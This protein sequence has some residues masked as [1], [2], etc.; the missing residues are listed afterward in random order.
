MERLIMQR[1]NVKLLLWLVG[2]AAAF[3]VGL[4]VVHQLQS[5]RIAEALLWQA[6][7]AEEQG[8]LKQAARYLAR[9]MEFQPEDL[10]ERAHLG[11][12]L[13]NPR[14]ADTYQSRANALFVLEQVVAREPDRQNLR[15]P[16]VRVATELGQFDLAAEHLQ[17]LLKEQPRD[18]EVHFLRGGWYEARKKYAR[19]QECYQ[20]AAELA[21][22][23]AKYPVRR[24][25]VLFAR[26]NKPREAQK[27]IEAARRQTPDDAG[28][29]LMAASLA[30]EQDQQA[31]AYRLLK[32][33]RRLYPRDPNFY[34]A[35]AGLLILD[36]R[37]PEAL[38]CLKDALK[39]LPR[40][41][42][43]DVLW[44]LTNL[45]LD[46]N[47]PGTLREA[48]EHIA[49]LQKAAL[50]PGATD[51]LDA[52]LL[53]GQ[54]DWAGA[55]RILE[56]IRPRLD[57]AANLVQEV[58]LYLGQCYEEL[59]DPGRRLDAYTL[60]VKANP[61]S[62]PARLGLAAA[63]GAM[64]KPDEALDNLKQATR[65]RRAPFRAWREYA[66]H[67]IARRRQQERPAWE[68]IDEALAEASRRARGPREAVEVVLLRAEALGARKE[69][70]QA[71]VYLE[72]EAETHP[73]QVDL[74]VAQVTL[75]EE[76]GQTDRAG[77][78]LEAMEKRFPAQV[79]PRL[80]RA[81][82]L[83]N[84][85]GVAA[86]N[87]LMKL[88]T[89]LERWD[90]EKQSN[91][92]RGLA[93][94]SYRANDL[95]AAARFLDR[96]AQLPLNRRDLRI[97]LRLFDLYLETK[98]QMGLTA[99][100]D[101][102]RRI[103]GEEGVWWRYGKASFL[104][105]QA[106]RSPKRGQLLDEAAGLLQAVAARRQRW[107]AVYTAQA[108]V[109]SL[110]G[111]QA[112]ALDLTRQALDMGENNPQI[113]RRLVR[114]VEA[115]ADREERSPEADQKFQHALDLAGHEPAIQVAYVRYLSVTG[116]REKALVAVEKAKSL[117]QSPQGRLALAQCY[118][119]VG[120]LKQA[121]AQYQ[122]ALGKRGADVATM[123]A[124][125]SFFMRTGLTEQAQPLLD[126]IL[127]RKISV[128]DADIAWARRARAVI[129]ADGSNFCKF[130]QALELIG[131][132]L[133]D[134]TG[135]AVEVS[136]PPGRERDATWRA[137][138]RVLAAQ[139][140]G[141]QRQQAIELL[142][143]LESRGRLEPDDRYLL[144][145]LFEAQGENGWRRARELLRALAAGHTNPAYH[146]HLAQSLLNHQ[147]YAEAS[148]AID[149]LARLE[150]TRAGREGAYGS[151]ELKARWLELTG[152]P[153]KA[154]RILQTYAGEKPLRAE[155]VLALAGLLARLT[156]VS[157]ALDQL[158]QLQGYP[159]EAVGGAAVGL[160]RSA[161]PADKDVARVEAFLLAALKKDPRSPVL[162]GQLADLY[163]LRGR[164]G[165][166][167]ARYRDV[168]ARD[169]DNVMALNNLAW[170]LAQRPKEAAEAE[171]LVNRAI[172]LLGP[173]PELLDTR[174]VV[175]LALGRSAAAVADLKQAN[176]DTP[177]PA[178]YFHL[179][180]ALH[181]E[182]RPAEALKALTK[183]KAAGLEPKGLHPAE[184]VQY[185]KINKELYER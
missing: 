2:G 138:A 66:R 146:G 144:A 69:F 47:E 22:K 60:A 161:K 57:Y 147:E 73:A 51:Y 34:K 95:R 16:L 158:E 53:M 9:Y 24:A 93:E 11:L 89:G 139:N 119:L 171:K 25:E 65:L 84:Q 7:R 101:Q 165:D 175:S 49:R 182:R 143:E 38:A 64:E 122:T 108:E 120:D 181:M 134:R 121:A 159:P 13:A 33:G 113:L 156:R 155:R 106:R 96:A 54:R 129:L 78:L 48:R 59:E 110:R 183:A 21:P 5:G 103:E 27:V 85:H 20:K 3:G 169:P 148:R 80:A 81:R 177:T 6:N 10:D 62:V 56:R 116:Q 42:H 26:L 107:S 72:R 173:R 112:Q 71:Q 152:Q 63:Q 18:A 117:L 153:D 111:N 8:D 124:A 149:K 172:N 82:F 150:K 41:H 1:I 46:M 87:S 154:L 164:F 98:N 79:E 55:A 160:L 114:Q 142:G 184:R 179:A 167:E 52:R 28:V 104:I 32:R 135:R 29:L 157:E 102:M 115:L 91:L 163:D 176:A 141:V 133:D 75:A 19:A 40:E 130:R 15:R 23:E 35:R 58:N 77:R 92:L 14:L 136:A 145:E 109:E 50:P 178:R 86:V 185:D 45:L 170:L 125:A 68:E 44:S 39:T 131:M 174:A 67:L 70:D 43:V 12:T 118:E 30:H 90:G 166:A 132:K 88:T 162:G 94:A 180:R 4:F 128:V 100:L 140:M 123:R 105:W 17:V 37:R 97:R 76:R 168:L 83:V 74:W 137:R 127:Q 126:M 151:V 36:N 61:K 99:V 31:A